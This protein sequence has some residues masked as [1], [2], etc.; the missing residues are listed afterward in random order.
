M[1]SM[2]GAVHQNHQ[3]AVP[4]GQ[5]YEDIEDLRR[6]V[7]EFTRRYNNERLIERHGHRMPHEAYAMATEAGA[8]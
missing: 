4:V 8:A 1:Q 5:L 2:R 7:M 3:G 6:A